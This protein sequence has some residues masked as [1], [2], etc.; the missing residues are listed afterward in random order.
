MTLPI[1]PLPKYPITIPSTGENH[2]FKPY[3]VKHQKALLIA[4]ES[5]D[6]KTMAGTLASII[7]ECFDGSI[8]AK[9]LALFDVIYI[10]TQMRAMSVGETIEITLRCPSCD[11]ENPNSYI[12]LPFDLKKLEV[13]RFDDHEKNIKLTDEGI[14][15]VM[16]YPTI[17]DVMKSNGV[18][19]VPL[20]SYIESIYTPDG[21][22][23]HSSSI[24]KD[25]LAEFINNIPITKM[26]EIN[27]FIRTIPKISHEFEM[28]CPVCKKHSSVLL[29]GMHAFFE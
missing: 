17:F 11:P 7:D 9:K 10:F 25:E 22:N 28:E 12:M 1:I 29:E 20:E 14:G 2:F 21:E 19:D 13:E 15:M 23:I 24:S 6:F 27:K 16:K 3:L 4:K 18:Y 8:D 26:K 5:E